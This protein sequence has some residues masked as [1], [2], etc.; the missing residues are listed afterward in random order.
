MEV[1][2]GRITHFYKKIGVAAVE[3]K[4]SLTVGDT[5]HIKGHTT[6]LEQKIESI[7]LEHQKIPKADM[8]QVVGVKVKDHVRENDLVYRIEP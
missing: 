5:I 8:G 3:V 6:D 4:E 1:L 2:V 7:E